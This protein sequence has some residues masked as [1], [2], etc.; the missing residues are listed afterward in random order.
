ML[1]GLPIAKVAEDPT[2]CGGDRWRL[3]LAIDGDSGVTAGNADRV[4]GLVSAVRHHDE[5]HTGS[6]C[7]DHRAVA[8]VGYDHAGLFEDF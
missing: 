4:V 6:Q 2:D 8:A 1:G 7:A 3:G 5:R